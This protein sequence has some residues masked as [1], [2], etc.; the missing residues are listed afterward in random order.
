MIVRIVDIGSNSIKTSVY[1]LELGQPRLLDKNKLELALGESVFDGGKN[2]GTIPAPA[3]NRL[4]RYL[5]SISDETPAMGKIERTWVVATSAVR[6]ATNALQLAEAIRKSTGWDMRVLTGS[7]ESY[8]IHRGIASATDLP[9]QEVLQTIDIG[10]GS[11]EAAWSRGGHYLGGWSLD[12]GAIRLTRKFLKDS[13]T[14]TRDSLHRIADHVRAALE[15]T[16]P[17]PVKKLGLAVA[18]SGNV[19]AI[20]KMAAA[21]KSAPFAKLLPEITI[22]ALEDLV[23]LGS[24]SSPQSLVSWFGLSPERA[25]IVMPAVIA[26]REG[27]RHF[28]IARLSVTEM[29]LREGVARYVATHGHLEITEPNVVRKEIG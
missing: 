10:G 28:G 15:K 1:L 23:E 22:G 21:L 16:G 8:L 19:R 2:H 27:L 25:R 14:F 9:R 5:E 12:L 11:F 6:D 24:D 7:E 4:C 29:G 20:A 26:L 3:I 18:S 13:P 17:A